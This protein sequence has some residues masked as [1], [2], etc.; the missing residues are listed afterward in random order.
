M[1]GDA[2]GGIAIISYSLEMDDGT[3]YV[4]L[5]GSVSDSTAT[6]FTATG[7]TTG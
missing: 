4:P 3:G 2:A 6:S 1:T 5:V 7:L